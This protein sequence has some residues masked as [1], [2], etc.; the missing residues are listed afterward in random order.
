MGDAR[1]RQL[2][3]LGLRT[4][5]DLIQWYP[6]AYED[7]RQIC[8]L[9]DA[10]A[11]MPVCI[12]AVTAGA[13]KAVHIRR[14]MDLCKVRI[15][16]ESG[17]CEVTFFNQSYV[18]NAL[19]ENHT[20]I[21]FGRVEGSAGRRTMTNPVFEEESASGQVTRCI[22]PVYRCTAGLSSLQLGRLIRD[23]LDRV[24]LPPDPLPDRLR[25]KYRLAHNGFAL[26]TIHRPPSYEEL[27]TARRRLIFEELFFLSAGL[28]ALKRRRVLLPGPKMTE[29]DFAPFYDALPFAPTGAQRRV[30]EQ[31]AAD[32]VSGYPM[33]RLIQGDVGSG[34]TVAAAGCV[35]LAAQ[36][37]FQ[38]ALMAPTEILARQHY[39]TLAPLLEKLGLRCVLLTGTL[40]AGERRA[41]LEALALG[42][43]AL[44]I[45]THAL[46]TA[47]VT[48]RNPGLVITD[49]QHRFG[50]AQRNTLAEKGVR[51]HVLV[52]S[53]TPIPRT[54]ALLLYGEL[55]VSILDELPPGRKP[56]ATYL[57]DESK[58][59]RLYGFAEKQ[60]EAG[61]QV[62]VVCP[63]VE[64]SEDL[65]N[66]TD[67]AKTLQEQVFPHRRVALLHGKMKDKGA[68]MA[69]FAAGESDLL[70]CTTVVEVGV[71][72]PNASLM[73]VENAERFGLSQLHQLRGRVGRGTHESYCVLVS[74]HGN[75]ETKARLQAFC[76]TNDG[77]AIAEEDL[78]LRGPGD[79]FGSRQHG[80]PELHIADLAGDVRLLQEAREAAE[81]LLAEDPT[82]SR[83]ENR[84]TKERIESLFRDSGERFN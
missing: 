11:D 12:R 64:E 44:V 69:A 75:P 74:D 40:R 47:D 48:F 2:E 13:P 70:V 27:A 81:D 31:A 76:S 55:D 43:A 20:Y 67:Y 15:V 59:Q 42:D 50:V 32:M 5:G 84:H 34:K 24:Q 36:N 46:L 45:G 56:V 16:D 77:F 73:I 83:P 19:K 18:R 23:A 10:P 9:K 26:E 8:L 33:N 28:S 21:F 29:R 65:K 38:S 30:I 51:P 4:V 7:R 82:L 53:A 78:K 58:R 71:D 72:V 60:M 25:Q 57:V 52:L 35:W 80:L 49:E 66:V 6:R 14:G 79:F 39:E 22:V 17:G 68:V 41:V 37:G 61:R 3:K 1:A 62:F 54:L 63:A